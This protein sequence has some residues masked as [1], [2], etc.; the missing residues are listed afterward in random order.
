MAGGS[1]DNPPKYEKILNLKNNDELMRGIKSLVLSKQNKFWGW[2]DPRTGLTM[3]LYLPFLVNPYFIVCYRNPLAI[4]KSLN[5]R[6][7]FSIEDSLKLVLIYSNRINYFLHK[8]KFPKLYLSYEDYFIDPKREI[9]KI[10]NFLK[11]NDKINVNKIV[12]L[13]DKNI[14][15]F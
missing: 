12:K 2:K 11:P 7:K 9:T 1:W 6:N 5:K 4:A 15:H 3:E 14:K 13:I 10:K 8:I